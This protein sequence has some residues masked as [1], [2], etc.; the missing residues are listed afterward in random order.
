[1]IDN[2]RDSD[3]KRKRKK[4]RK[5]LRDVNERQREKNM[6]KLSSRKRGEDTERERID[7]RN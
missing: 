4:V 5:C 2:E 7:E 1:L 3:R 6:Y